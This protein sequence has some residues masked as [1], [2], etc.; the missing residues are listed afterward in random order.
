MSPRDAGFGKGHLV[1]AHTLHLKLEILGVIM[2][3]VLTV[4]ALCP[5]QATAQS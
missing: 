4:P 3:K 5:C 1:V 2:G